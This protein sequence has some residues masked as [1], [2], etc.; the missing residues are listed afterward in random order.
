MLYCAGC[1]CDSPN[2][3]YCDDCAKDA[4]CPHGELHID[5]DDCDREADLAFDAA[6]EAR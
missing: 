6:R 4:R 5:C 3:I 2:T 1:G